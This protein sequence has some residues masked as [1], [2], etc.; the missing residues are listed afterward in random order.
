M[1]ES[2]ARPDKSPVLETVT[3]REV[4]GFLKTRDQFE[5]AVLALQESGFERA[6]IELMAGE[7]TVREKLFDIYTPS[8]KVDVDRVKPREALRAMTK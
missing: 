7:H 1:P 4:V 5:A 8:P 2:V 6:D 3:A